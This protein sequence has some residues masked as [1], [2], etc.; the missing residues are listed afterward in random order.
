MIENKKVTIVISAF[1]KEKYIQKSIKSVLDQSYTNIELFI[2]DDG[3]TDK[4]YEQIKNF[5]FLP[6]ENLLIFTKKNEG[7]ASCRNIGIEKGSGDYILFLDGD[8]TL[9]PN[10]IIQAVNLLE[11]TK[12]SI[13]FGGWNYIDENDKFIKEFNVPSFD[14]YLEKLL[15]GNIF[16]I[17]SVFC[18]LHFLRSKV[19]K[20]KFYTV[21]DDW[22]Y[23]IRCAKNN[24]KFYRSGIIFS[25]VRIYQ[26]NNKKNLE[27][28][29][30]RFFPVIED[31]FNKNYF[32]P[33]K[34]KKLKKISIL[35][36]HFYLMEN[37]IHWNLRDL[38]NEQFYKIVAILKIDKININF[39]YE[40]IYLL[41]FTKF[42]KILFIQKLNIKNY[43]K[44]F[45]FRFYKT[46]K[47]K[48]LF[49]FFLNKFKYIK[50]FF[51][52]KFSLILTNNIF[53]Q[54]L[55]EKENKLQADI[56]ILKIREKVIGFIEDMKITKK[57]NLIGYRF[58]KNSFQPTCYNLIFVLLIKH[59]MNI[60]DKNIQHELEILQTYQELDGYFRDKK[61]ASNYTNGDLGG[62]GW[63]HLT[64]HALM[65]F[66][67]YNIKPKF[68]IPI[69]YKINNSD[70]LSKWLRN[71]DVEKQA[72]DAG[73]KIQNFATSIQFKKYF[74]SYKDENNYLSQ[75]YNFLNKNQNKNNGLFGSEYLNKK[76]LMHGI[77]GGYHLWLLY[78]YDGREINNSDKIIDSLIKNQNI[79][80]GFGIFLNSSACED[81]DSVDPL[82]R[83][84]VRQGKKNQNILIC[85]NKF[86]P[87]LLKNLN[88]DGSWVFR[89]NEACYLFSD[90]MYSEAN[91]GNLFYTW[92][93]LLNLA[94]IS[95]VLA[96]DNR[97]FWNF[98][99]IFK[100]I[101]GHQF[102][103]EKDI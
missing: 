101:P 97:N 10:A 71:M 91:N 16:A 47:I 77:I 45:F 35:R 46:K 11:I 72:I 2:I 22:E 29:K 44:L 59:L 85:L 32:L 89:R 87:S 62:W 21:T 34:Y 27:K 4:T 7:V 103:D 24:A 6:K 95:K 56:D 13:V 94:Y 50:N 5:K 76:D 33:D 37:Y 82:V 86:L 3:T 14:D 9:M 68:N 65:V 69:F 40:F 38:S 55:F 20:Y 18:D 78:F 96:D 74:E 52:S 42:L 30:K 102:L 12:S 25:N 83:F 93:R 31:V 17:C 19:G 99:F 61:I 26:D 1:N 28:Q 66:A 54:K 57:E 41:T 60:E 23:W 79:S 43:F 36:H 75:I 51:S 84:F 49:K 39:Y 88:D 63:E 15:L 80:G 53:M 92:F 70:E 48:F 100:R 90:N 8:D 64:L 73:N 98:K 67:L 81:I 58:S